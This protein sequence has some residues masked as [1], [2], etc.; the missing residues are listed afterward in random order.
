LKNHDLTE[1]KNTPLRAS[2]KQLTAKATTLLYT[3]HAS[4]HAPD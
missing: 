2:E 3:I 1:M 4:Q